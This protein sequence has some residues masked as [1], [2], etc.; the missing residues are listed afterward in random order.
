MQSH[1]YDITKMLVDH[2]DRNGLNNQKENLRIC[3]YSKNA[4]N[5]KRNPI[6]G[7]SN[8][9]GVYLYKRTNKYRANIKLKGKRIYLGYFDSD[10]EAALAY[11]KKAIEL[12]GEY[13]C[14]NIITF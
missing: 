10:K 3:D 12:F 9:K 14:L 6:Y 11:N 7:S 4:Q 8:Y 1:D 5:S 2:K 13:A